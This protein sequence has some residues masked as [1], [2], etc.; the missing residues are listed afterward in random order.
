MIFRIRLP[1][2][3]NLLGLDRDDS[4]RTDVGRQTDVFRQIKE[5]MEAPSGGYYY[6]LCTCICHDISY[7]DG[8]F[9]GMF[10]GY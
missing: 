6:Q 8:E 3:E 2:L 5:P 1:R 10:Q 7:R 9:Y 4:D